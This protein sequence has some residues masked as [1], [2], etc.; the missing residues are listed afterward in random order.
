MHAPVTIYHGRRIRESR[1]LILRLETGDAPS[2]GQ[3]EQPG[4]SAV[5]FRG[6]HYIRQRDGEFRPA[7][8]I[9]FAKRNSPD[10]RL[11]ERHARRVKST[12]RLA[13][14]LEGSGTAYTN[15]V[16]TLYV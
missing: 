1:R 16:A 7:S 8:A 14:H 12:A 11:I 6:A 9:R 2:H 10:V 15:F 5:V 13:T 4:T 3:R